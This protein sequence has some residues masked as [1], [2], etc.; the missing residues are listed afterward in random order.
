[1][2]LVIYNDKT[3]YFLSKYVKRILSLQSIRVAALR[4]SVLPMGRTLFRLRLTLIARFDLRIVLGVS[5]A[6]FSGRLRDA[7]CPKAAGV[8]Q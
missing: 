8:I 1:M 3:A 5:R 4:P 7:A 2:Q 6:E